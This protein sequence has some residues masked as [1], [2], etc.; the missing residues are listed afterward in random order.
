[1]ASLPSSAW[2]KEKA[3]VLLQRAG[4]GGT[5]GEAEALSRMSPRQAADSLL[6]P[7]EAPKADPPES[8]LK[9]SLNDKLRTLRNR[10]NLLDPK[11][12]EEK[13]REIL[14]V[15][16]AEQEKRLTDL[17][18]WWLSRMADPGTAAREKMVL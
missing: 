7:A 9:P 18:G 5:P 8:I 3:A 14:R 1:M 10:L 15:L 2:D 4:F 13:R 6:G 12:Q 16:K 11:T 17:R